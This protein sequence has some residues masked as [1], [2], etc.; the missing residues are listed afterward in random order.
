MEIEKS[1]KGEKTPFWMS[2]MKTPFY[3]KTLPKYVQKKGQKWPK[4]GSKWPILGHF[5]DSLCIRIAI[6]MGQKT[7]KNGSRV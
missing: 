7:G 1:R 6:K 4:N 2:R 5:Y 3:R